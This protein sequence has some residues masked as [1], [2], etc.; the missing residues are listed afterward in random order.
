MIV[1]SP[2]ASDGLRLRLP[3]L[4][5]AVGVDEDPVCGS[6]HCCLGPF[7]AAKLGRNELTGH[8]VSRRGGVVKV[9]VEGVRV[10]LIGQAVT[11][12]RAELVG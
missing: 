7:W 5:P 12:M 4:R 6:A 9:R 8:Q 11:V 10:A 1:T 2:G 3:L